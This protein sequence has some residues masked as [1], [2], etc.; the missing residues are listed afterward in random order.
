MTLTD[1]FVASQLLGR[2]AY[3]HVLFIEPSLPAKPRQRPQATPC[4]RHDPV[5]DDAHTSSGRITGPWTVLVEIGDEIGVIE[6]RTASRGCCAA[7]RIHAC[8]TAVADTWIA[9]EC[10]AYG[11]PRPALGQPAE[12][13]RTI[14]D[15]ITAV[16]ADQHCEPR[17]HVRT[18]TADARP[19][20]DRFPL[21]GELARLWVA[22]TDRRPVVSWLNHCASLDDISRYLRKRSTA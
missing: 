22:S 19:S 10:N 15:A 6:C 4:C 20:V 16:F 14:A 8:T 13:S 21:S 11:C 3:F 9:T 2:L 1:R 18:A 7:C 12:W 5:H 17:A